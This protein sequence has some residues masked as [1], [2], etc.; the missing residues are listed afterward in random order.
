MDEVTKKE[1]E[2]MGLLGYH[3]NVVTLIGTKRDEKAG[4]FIITE[5]CAG[6]L[7][8]Y[9]KLNKDKLYYYDLLVMAI[10]IA[11]GMEH[12]HSKNIVHLDLALRNVL[13]TME[14]YTVVCKISDFGLSYLLNPN[15]FILPQNISIPW[16]WSSPETIFKKTV[17]EKADIFAFGYVLL[18]LFGKGEDP[19]PNM[20]TGELR[21]QYESSQYK[22]FIFS[23]LDNINDSPEIKDVV[24]NECWKLDPKERPSFTQM[25]NVLQ[26]LYSGPVSD[27]QPYASP[28]DEKKLY[29][30]KIK[31]NS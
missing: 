14:G 31:Y 22:E 16:K 24:T 15:P 11:Q 30:P 3:K 23:N 28:P 19:Y 13:F 20:T 9:I 10:Q 18:E 17:T 8:H 26:K 25:I 2:L 12:I 5:L 27:L 4:D 6:D 7:K 1:L 21:Q 29:Q